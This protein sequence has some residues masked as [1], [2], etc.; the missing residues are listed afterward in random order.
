MSDAGLAQGAS[1]ALR[2]PPEVLC[3]IVDA[4]VGADL[5][6]LRT[7]V[8]GHS[9]EPPPADVEARRRCSCVINGPQPLCRE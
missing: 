4:F 1:P 8:Y 2:L 7:R 5:D 3:L 9:L 6:D